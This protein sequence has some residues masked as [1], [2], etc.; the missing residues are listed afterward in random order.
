MNRVLDAVF[1][2]GADKNITGGNVSKGRNSKGGI[3]LFS[4]VFKRVKDSDE[5][6][7]TCKET[8]QAVLIGDNCPEPKAISMDDSCINRDVQSCVAVKE[9]C[10]PGGM[11]DRIMFVNWPIKETGQDAL[12]MLESENPE[13]IAIA[14][15]LQ[16]EA[17]DAENLELTQKLTIPLEQ[18]AASHGQSEGVLVN[19][20][21][22]HTTINEGSTVGHH[23]GNNDSIQHVAINENKNIENTVSEARSTVSPQHQDT[24]MTGIR[25][26]ITKTD[27]GEIK[28]IL[29]DMVNNNGRSD[30]DTDENNAQMKQYRDLNNAKAQH[31]VTKS[32]NE[33]ANVNIQK[34]LERNEH[35][36]LDSPVVD[37]GNLDSNYSFE[38]KILEGQENVRGNYDKSILEQISSA[39]V[40][41]RS[42]GKS[43]ELLLKL[44]PESLGRV[45]V[46]VTLEGD[47]MVAKFLAS[48]YETKCIIEANYQQLEDALNNQGFNVTKVEVYE[49]EGEINGMPDKP[50]DRDNQSSKN[51]EHFPSDD[52]RQPSVNR[53]QGV[54]ETIGL[55]DIM[56]NSSVNYFA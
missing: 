51:K 11:V 48:S 27:T 24:V 6:K 3:S 5:E 39:I 22:I 18:S 4:D 12:Q 14:Q 26:F 35:A 54:E 52:T 13:G 21:N 55:Y 45:M 33:Y 43:W 8:V 47:S 38:G 7:H 2:K 25:V 15:G 30:N 32:G 1:V 49:M 17:P 37:M 19:D 46:K 29:E 53:V 36:R 40:K 28:P 44:E 31:P 50:Y 20:E 42:F 9:D 16:F 23:I 34:S 56:E 41:Q 10:F